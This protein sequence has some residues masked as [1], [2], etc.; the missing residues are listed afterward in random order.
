MLQLRIDTD[1]DAFADE[2]GVSEVAM[3]LRVVAAHLE[4]GGELG[5]VISD[6]NGNACG[7]W[8]LSFD[9]SQEGD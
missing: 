3:L 5:G 6:S 1:N 9:R 2:R 4:T 7:Q 8:G